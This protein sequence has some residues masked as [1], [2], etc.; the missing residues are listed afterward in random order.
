MTRITGGETLVR[1]LISEGVDTVFGIPATSLIQLYDALYRHQGEICHIL[2][3][4]EQGVAFMADGYARSTGKAG[5]AIVDPGPGV[6]NAL[7]AI[8][9]AHYGSSPLLVVTI[10]RAGQDRVLEY[11]TKWRRTVRS[12]KEIPY[13]LQE[14]FDQLRFQRAVT[15]QIPRNILNDKADVGFPERKDPP[16]PPLPSEEMDR[17]ASWLVQSKHPLI[18]AGERATRCGASS[19]LLRLAEQ[20]QAP[21]L[22][23]P[24]GKGVIP[25]HHPLALGNA[26]FEKGA[27]DPLMERIDLIIGVGASPT[28]MPSSRFPDR[29]I[30]LD[31]DPDELGTERERPLG[32]AGHL[33]EILRTLSQKLTEK[34]RQ[35]RTAPIKEIE[36]ARKKTMEI[37]ESY[38]LGATQ[39]LNILK[40]LRSALKPDAIL[41]ADSLIGLWA[42]RCFDILI[43]RG[44]HFPMG[45]GTLGF[46]VPAAIG[47][48]VGNPDR[49]VVALCGDGAF[50]FTANELASAVQARTPIV[51][52]VCNDRA[53]GA[54]KYRQRTECGGRYIATDLVN[55]DFAAFAAS[56]G[57]TGVKLQDPH[58]LRSAME[59]AVCA[60]SVTV[61]DVPVSPSLDPPV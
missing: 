54:I 42:N 59:Q 13:A 36:V 8:G 48:K 37:A 55:P 7:T 15:L 16:N 3:R 19:E 32:I 57:A 9:E 1:S 6:T 12:A 33:P 41:M 21:M 47:A 56:F 35:K 20:L 24:M 30:H 58:E 34:D 11:A 23:R 52:V 4:H 43:P 29:Q 50:M 61:I 5:V 38:G 25:E 22:V 31:V 60:E 46:S 26:W 10:P 45:F 39:A 53:Y 51:V 18:Y 2:A 49:Q 44:Y 17:A 14:A 28:S 40:D 27:G